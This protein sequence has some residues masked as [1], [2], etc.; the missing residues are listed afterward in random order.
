MAASGSFSKV[1][2]T[3]YTLLVEWTESNV[4]APNNQSDITVTAKLKEIG[5]AHV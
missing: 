1:F 4:D 3:G 2:S 5:R